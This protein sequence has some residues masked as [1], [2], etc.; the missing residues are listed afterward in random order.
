MKFARFTT[1]LGIALLTFAWATAASIPGQAK[2]DLYRLIG[3]QGGSL[4]QVEPFP[5]TYQQMSA[6]R[7]MMQNF[8]IGAA[9]LICLAVGLSSWKQSVEPGAAPSG[10]PTTRLDNPGV[11][12]GAPSVS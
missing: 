10:G 1:I 8:Y 11:R 3:P 7:R 9:G 5:E 12:E 2:Q 6:N 4:A